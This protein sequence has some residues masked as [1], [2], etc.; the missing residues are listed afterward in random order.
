M[1]S[2]PVQGVNVHHLVEVKRIGRHRD[3]EQPQG[4]RQH[5]NVV[6][7]V[8]ILIVVIDLSS[9]TGLLIMP[10][11]QQRIICSSSNPCVRRT[12]KVGSRSVG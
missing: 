10:Y 4:H 8:I 2:R 1:R 11:E 12:K 5:V 9:A 6:T 7:A 3:P